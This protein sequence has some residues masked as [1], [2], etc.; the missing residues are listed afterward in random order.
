MMPPAQLFTVPATLTYWPCRAPS[1]PTAVV[2]VPPRAR[3]V[4]QS[5]ESGHAE[6]FVAADL[7]IGDECGTA[8]SREHPDGVGIARHRY[9]TVQLRLTRPGDDGVRKAST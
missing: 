4:R 2:V 3:V 1:A 6:R 5:L 7:V 8:G 9:A